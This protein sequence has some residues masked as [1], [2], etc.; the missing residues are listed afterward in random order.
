MVS[1]SYRTPVLVLTTMLAMHQV[2]YARVVYRVGWL[3]RENRP[4]ACSYSDGWRKALVPGYKQSRHDGSRTRWQE[5]M[6]E[7]R[8]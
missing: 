4:V 6:R 3:I 2:H 5:N 1:T 8:E 7:Y